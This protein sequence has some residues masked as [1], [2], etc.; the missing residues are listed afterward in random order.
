MEEEKKIRFATL[1]DIKQWKL[2]EYQIGFF[3]RNHLMVLSHIHISLRKKT[4]NIFYI[5]NFLTE[6]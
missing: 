3:A 2:R 6:N 1:P 4:K 5:H